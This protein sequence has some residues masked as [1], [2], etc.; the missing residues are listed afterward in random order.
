METS[1]D[2]RNWTTGSVT[3]SEPDENGHRT[4]SVERDGPRRFLQLKVSVAD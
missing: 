2:L 1:T 3:W 4:A